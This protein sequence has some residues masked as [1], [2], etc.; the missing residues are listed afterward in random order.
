V[1][2][3]MQLM[4]ATVVAALVVACTSSETDPVAPSHTTGARFNITPTATAWYYGTPRQPIKGWGI[5]PAGGSNPFYSAPNVQSAIYQLGVTHVRDAIDPALYV[6]GTTV[7]NMVLNTRLLNQ[8]VAKI[9]YAKAHGAESYVLAV[10]SP[11]AVWK[12][13]HSLLGTYNGQAGYLQTWAEPYFEAFVTKVMLALKSSS[14]GLPVA[15]SIQNEPAHLAPY[16]GCQYPP[17]QWRRVMQNVRASF[18]YWGLKSVVLFG[19]ETG[20]YTPGLFSNFVTRAPGYFGGINYPSLSG[21]L[22]YAVGAY[23]Y[24]TYA[25]CSLALTQ[26]AVALHPKDM[27][28]TEFGA[29]S[30]S[31]ELQWTLDLMS[32]M[33]AH[34]IIV[35]NNY[36]FWWAGWSP[37]TGAPSYGQL[38]GGTTN[39]IYSKR[40]W[41]LK[42]LF[43]TVRPWWRVHQLSTSDPSLQTGWGTQNQC[44]ARV[45]LIGFSSPDGSHVVIEIVNTSSSNKELQI[46]GLPSAFSVQNSWRTDAWSDMVEQH[47]TNVY[48]GFSTISAPANSV[49]IAQMY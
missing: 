47:A 20:Q 22:D 48:H 10:W 24:H 36:W 40:Y 29:P 16:N 49:V 46:G 26:Q 8:Y 2:R 33:A 11:P 15:F 44:L 27:W 18:D 41:A 13:N 42:K 6:S 28:M 12:T 21:Y 45:N 34:L 19:P 38:L 1:Y 43:T 35:P 37:T 7:S 17:D 9:A 31:N 4:A 3:S 5:Y 25:E 23:A 39:P 30:G 14:I 32:A